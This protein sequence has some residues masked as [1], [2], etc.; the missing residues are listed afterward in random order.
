MR[1]TILYA[2]AYLAALAIILFIFAGTDNDK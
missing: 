1:E 2:L